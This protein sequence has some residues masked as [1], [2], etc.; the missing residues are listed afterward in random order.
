MAINS[1]FM[2]IEIPNILIRKYSKTVS[3]GFVTMQD[4]LLRVN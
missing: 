4:L 1:E 2:A 3:R